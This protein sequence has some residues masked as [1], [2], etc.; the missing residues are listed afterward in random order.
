MEEHQELSNWKKCSSCGFCIKMERKFMITLKELNPT[1]SPVSEEIQKNMDDLLI[2]LNKFRTAYSIPMKV[3]SGLRTMSDH[4]RIY[5]SINDKRKDKGLDPIKIPM[6]SAHLNGLACDFA[7]PQ[8]TL[9]NW[10]F[11]NQK[12][13]E[14][15][16][17][18]A[19][20][21][22][23]GWLHLQSRPAHNRFFK[24]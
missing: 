12:L 6:G 3:T 8:G 14:E 7:D 1:N 13:L 23:E 19:E 9:Y 22:T 4:E 16:G 17:L 18:W 10:A 5:K 15:I 21:D 24:P 2:K 20:A 11:S